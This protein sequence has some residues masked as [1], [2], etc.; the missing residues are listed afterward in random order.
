MR[1]FQPQL[2]KTDKDFN[3]VGPNQI[4]VKKFVDFFEVHAKEHFG[5]R[6]LCDDIRA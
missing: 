3:L 2:K 1:I 6:V 4:A 5:G